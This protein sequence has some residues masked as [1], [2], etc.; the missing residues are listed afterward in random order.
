MSRRLCRVIHHKNHIHVSAYH[1]PLSFKTH[2]STRS[3]TNYL[4]NY[5]RQKKIGKKNQSHNYIIY[6]EVEAKIDSC[7]PIITLLIIISNTLT[8]LGNCEIS[9][10]YFNSWILWKYLKDSDAM[11]LNRRS[12]LVA[13]DLLHQPHN[14]QRHCSKSKKDNYLF[15][16][17][18]LFPTTYFDQMSSNLW[19]K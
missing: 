18:S 17:C 6:Q 19:P 13:S 16:L 2:F 4:S 14:F 8:L 10:F 3:N 1:R 12:L 15:S 5:G 9:K 11:A 7:L